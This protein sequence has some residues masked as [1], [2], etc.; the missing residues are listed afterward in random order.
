MLR[1]R[2]TATN[3]NGE[4]CR[5]FALPGETM[6]FSHHPGKRAEVKAARRRGGENRSNARRAAKTLALEGRQLR[7]EDLPDVLR[8]CVLRVVNGEMEPGQASAVAALARTTLQVAHDL[9]LEA[10]IAALEEAA[11]VDTMPS[12]VRRIA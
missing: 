2:C 3:R 9:E 12:N 5:A 4:P 7:S 10:R 11:G 8:A 6:C 1:E